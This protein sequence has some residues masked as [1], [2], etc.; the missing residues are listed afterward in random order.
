M[1]MDIQQ[2]YG[3]AA[4]TWHMN[5]DKQDGHGHINASW[6]KAWAVSMDMDMQHLLGMDIGMQVGH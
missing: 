1:D 4:W 5:T 6:V 2:G 3:H